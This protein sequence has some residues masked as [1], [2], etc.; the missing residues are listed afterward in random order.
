MR[1]LN[2]SE[3]ALLLGFLFFL[4]IAE[5]PK[6]ILLYLFF[7]CWIFV[8]AK[9]KRWGLGDRLIEAP[10]L[11]ISVLSLIS[12]PLQPQN[13]V[14][15]VGKAMDF[16]AIAL[17]LVVISRMSLTAAAAKYLSIALVAGVFIGLI[18]GYVRW[19]AFPTLSSVGHVNQVAMYFTVVFSAALAWGF[20]ASGTRQHAAVFAL[21]FSLIFLVSATGSRNALFGAALVTATAIVVGFSVG[22]WKRSVVWLI[23]SFVG[24]A[25]TFVIFTPPSALERQINLTQTT[26]A[27]VD[28]GRQ[29]IWKGAWLVFSEKPILGHGV[30]GFEAATSPQRIESVLREAGKP[31]NPLDYLKINH[32]H[33]T[34]LNWLVERG[35]IATGL[36]IFWMSVVAF[37]LCRQFKITLIDLQ[38]SRRYQFSALL[39]L[40]STIF[41]GIGNTTWHHEHGMLAAFILG[42]A[43]S[44]ERSRT[45]FRQ[46]VE[47]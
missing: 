23:I 2:R 3:L 27:I 9:E 40:F 21:L 37:K 36:F 11:A 26:G 39:V 16:I 17:L 4:P 46:N 42:I 35:A 20:L 47:L 6:N 1:T 7:G 10:L 32:A 19:G 8:C 44:L 29:R 22:L 5:A 15:A 13:Y 43:L 25:S 24:I 34:L 45:V 31:Y 12:I 33:N 14:G 30:G 18:E 38:L 28:D 41:M